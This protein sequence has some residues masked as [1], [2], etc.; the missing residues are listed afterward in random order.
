MG[1]AITKKTQSAIP[2]VPWQKLKKRVLGEKYDLSLVL[3]NDIIIK[4]LNKKYLRKNKTAG[5]LA[6]PLTDKEGEVFICPLHIKK[7]AKK[8]KF[9]FKDYLKKNFIHGL[10]HLKGFKHGKKMEEEEKSLEK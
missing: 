8:Y 10:L 6:F 5:V 9:D 2:D 3:T 4:K 7:E 1:F